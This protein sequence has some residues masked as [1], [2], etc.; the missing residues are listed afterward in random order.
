MEKTMRIKVTSEKCSG[1][2]LCEMICSIHH[3]GVV[4]INRSGIHIRKDDLKTG[5]CQP[6]VCRHCKKMVCLGENQQDARERKTRFIWELALYDSCPF[7]ALFQWKSEVYHCDLCGGEPECVKICS[8][9]AIEIDN[10]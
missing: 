2:H 8:S 6:V 5:Y 3:L 4:N 7:D 10:N 9:G 1:C